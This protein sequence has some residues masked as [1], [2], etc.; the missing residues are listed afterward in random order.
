[1]LSQLSSSMLGLFIEVL[2]NSFRGF[3]SVYE[4]F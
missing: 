3:M 4:R 2:E 1:M